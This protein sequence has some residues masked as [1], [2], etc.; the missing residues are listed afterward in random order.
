MSVI[1]R[2]QA[3]LNKLFFGREDAALKN[4]AKSARMIEEDGLL[5]RSQCS[6]SERS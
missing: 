5:K 1:K 6:R 2:I 4:R 3:Y